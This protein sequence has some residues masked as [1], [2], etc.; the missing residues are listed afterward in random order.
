MRKSGKLTPY[1]KRKLSKFT[2]LGRYIGV[3][4]KTKEYSGLLY[5]KFISYDTKLPFPNLQQ[6]DAVYNS[7]T[8]KTSIRGYVH[9]SWTAETCWLHNA[10]KFI[11]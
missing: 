6:S 3:L 5:G 11:P 4:G 1:K 10:F 9:L 8:G 7:F 2:L